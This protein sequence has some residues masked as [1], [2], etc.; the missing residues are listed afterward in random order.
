MGSRTCRKFPGYYILSFAHYPSSRVELLDFPLTIGIGAILTPP[1]IVQVS[2]LSAVE[3]AV[4]MV[5]HV[6]SLAALFLG[7]GRAYCV[8]LFM[9][10]GVP[11]WRDSAQQLK[12]SM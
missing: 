11:G 6:L 1:L 7:L 3:A 8:Q 4:I 12:Q 9:V 2:Q 10:M 5:Y